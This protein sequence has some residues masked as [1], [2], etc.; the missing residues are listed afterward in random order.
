MKK[1]KNKL[2]EMQEQTLLKIEKNGFYM[3]FF[4]LGLAIVIQDL[5]Y[6][7]NMLL[8][9]AGEMI[10]FVICG[11]YVLISSIRKGIWDRK[12]P[13]TPLANLIQSIL[14]SGA[15]S[16]ILGVIKY[17]QY[18]SPGGAVASAVIFFAFISVVCFITLT[19][20][21]AFY[22]NRKEKLENQE[23]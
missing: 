8:Y 3:I 6:R 4:G 18:G 13:A 16:I 23:D 12:I 15:F 5:I 22:K 1:M 10:V 2:D 14:W 9:T 20:L 17:F 7:E 19:I 21:A 11:I